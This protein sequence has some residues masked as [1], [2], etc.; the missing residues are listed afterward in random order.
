[1]TRIQHPTIA[2]ARLDVAASKVGDWLE[3]GW[4]LVDSPPKLPVTPLRPFPV[5]G[6]GLFSSTKITGGP[7]GQ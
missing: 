4:L 5:P 3:M 1:M 6:G 2:A 7:H